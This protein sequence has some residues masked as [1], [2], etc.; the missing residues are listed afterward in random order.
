MTMEDGS[1]MERYV[2]NLSGGVCTGRNGY[3]KM[4]LGIVCEEYYLKETES[5]FKLRFTKNCFRKY[6]VILEI[7][8][9][10]RLIT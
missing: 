3:L 5:F 1:C 2:I 4:S 6:C 7:L 10:T 8:R 9:K